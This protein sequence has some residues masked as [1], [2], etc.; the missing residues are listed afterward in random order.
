MSKERG[1]ERKF[2]HF[3]VRSSLFDILRFLAIPT[4]LNQ[5]HSP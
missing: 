1:L 4:P 2:L 5:E 3:V